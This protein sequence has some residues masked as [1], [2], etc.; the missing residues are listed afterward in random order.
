MP[1]TPVALAL[2]GG[3]DSVLLLNLLARSLPRPRV[4]AIHV[5]HGLRGEEADGDAA[6]CAR[7]CARLGVPFALRT[8]ELSEEASNLEARARE[9]RYKALLDAAAA[10]NIEVLVTGHHEDDALETLLMRWMRGS[11]LAGLSGP[12]AQRV[13]RVGKGRETKIEVV[14]PLRS[15]RRE[16]VRR[17]LRDHGIAWRE[18][19]SNASS[20]FTR[21]RV[22][23]QLLPKIGE[24]C[25]DE[26]IEN[27][28][29]FANAVEGLEEELAART[30]HLAWSPPAHAAASRTASDVGLGGT[31]DRTEL[32]RLAAPLKRRALWR[33]LQEGTGQPPTRAQLT[34]LT[35][36]LDAGRTGRINLQAGWTLVLRRDRVHL[37]PETTAGDQPKQP[38]QTVGNKQRPSFADGGAALEIPGTVQLPDGRALEAELVEAEPESDAPRS[39]VEVELDARD[40]PSE[41]LVRFAHPGDRFHGLGAPGSRPLTRFLADAGVPREERR[42]IPLVFAGPELIWV[43]GLRPCESRRVGPATSVRLRIRLLGAALGV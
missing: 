32:Q 12:K 4:L 25:G 42:R 23:N 38:N 33:L 31:L 15:M 13:L 22:R 19:S 3:A 1:T 37:V 17:L 29:A 5:D 28:R 20:R 24:T 2:S 36:D 11:H 41:L 10:Q 40:L 35:A 39:A 21:N 18:D 30:A 27:L 43:A 16:E 26:G 34:Q 6:F 7:A 8:V 14:R 9:E